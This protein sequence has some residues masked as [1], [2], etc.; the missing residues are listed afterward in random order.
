VGESPR[1]FESLPLRLWWYQVRKAVGGLR[2]RLGQAG[3]VV[4]NGTWLSPVE[5]SLR[6]RGVAGSN[7]AVPTERASS[8]ARSRL[9]A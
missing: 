8:E 9:E 5:H 2:R 6:E 4:G 3:E 1:G 7:P